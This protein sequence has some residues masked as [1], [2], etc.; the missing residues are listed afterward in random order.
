MNALCHFLII[1]EEISDSLVDLPRRTLDCYSLDL[2]DKLTLQFL[3]PLLGAHT[4]ISMFECTF[5][6]ACFIH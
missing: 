1:Y 4:L 5:S 6:I 2:D 3:L